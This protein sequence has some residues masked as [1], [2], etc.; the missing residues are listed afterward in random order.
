MV[1]FSI[2]TIGG[3][4]R[5]TD[6]VLEVHHGGTFTCGPMKVYI[7]GKIDTI[8]GLDPDYISMLELKA[9]AQ[10]FGYTPLVIFYFKKSK[11]NLDNGLVPI[12]T[13]KDAYGMME[14]L[15]KDRTVIVYLEHVGGVN[16]IESQTSSSNLG[17]T[18]VALQVDFNAEEHNEFLDFVLEPNFETGLVNLESGVGWEYDNMEVGMGFNTDFGIGGVDNVNEEEE[19][20]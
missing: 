19:P 15:H 3:F 10:K 20:S 1:L 9:M 5:P 6:F 12:T 4:A 8:Y 7:G 2:L 17:P 18:T 13:D 11:C 16:L 14:L